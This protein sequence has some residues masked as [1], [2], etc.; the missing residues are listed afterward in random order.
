MYQ[1]VAVKRKKESTGSGRGEIQNRR[2][3]DNRGVEEMDH[4]FYVGW[5]EKEI[6]GGDG[7]M[8]KADSV[9]MEWDRL[10][11]ILIEQSRVMTWSGSAVELEF[12]K[13]LNSWIFPSPA[14]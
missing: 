3:V 4:G 6:Q 5:R 2:G 7:E 8:G 12:L 1:S 11:E 10:G 13:T 14:S 9:N